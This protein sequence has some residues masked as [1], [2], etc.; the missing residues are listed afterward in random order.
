MLPA[1][2]SSRTF[3]RRTGRVATIARP[4]PT[5]APGTMIINRIPLA[6]PLPRPPLLLRDEGSPPPDR[7]HTEIWPHGD[8]QR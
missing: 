1:N 5:T 4:V 8:E 7:G 6:P 2:R 3:L